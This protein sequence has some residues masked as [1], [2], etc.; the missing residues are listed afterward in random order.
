[1]TRKHFLGL[2]SL[3]SCVAPDISRSRDQ[4]S[5]MTGEALRRSDYEGMLFRFGLPSAQNCV[6]NYPLPHSVTHIL[7]IYTPS[8]QKGDSIAIVESVLL[9]QFPPKNSSHDAHVLVRRIQS[10]VVIS[11]AIYKRSVETVEVALIQSETEG[12][13]AHLSAILRKIS[14]KP[15]ESPKDVVGRRPPIDAGVETF[16]VDRAWRNNETIKEARCS[17]YGVRDD[18]FSVVENYL[19]WFSSCLEMLTK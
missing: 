15:F 2:L 8:Y 10:P 7:K 6:G 4:D 19:V 17:H 18:S 11:S 14:A 12:P 5:E 3:S 13:T 9:I 16:Y 1:M